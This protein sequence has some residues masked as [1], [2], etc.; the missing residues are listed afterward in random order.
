MN[1][2]QKS[3]IVLYDYVMNNVSLPI[4]HQL[5]RRVDAMTRVTS[6]GSNDLWQVLTAFDA[7]DIKRAMQRLRMPFVHPIGV[8]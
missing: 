5:T 2:Q 3:S 7:D 8:G 1:E 6:T 4:E